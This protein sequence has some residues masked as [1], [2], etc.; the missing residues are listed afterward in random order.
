MREGAH[1]TLIEELQG[2]APFGSVLDAGTGPRSV[3]W[4][5]KLETDSWT[6]VTGDPRMRDKVDRQV[7][8]DKRAQDRLLLGNWNDPELL[9]GETFDTV[10]ADHLLGAIEGFAPFFQ[11]ALFPRLRR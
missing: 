6:A 5:M 3:R 1:F 11:T 4:L 10:V 7:G 2:N 9:A 8:E